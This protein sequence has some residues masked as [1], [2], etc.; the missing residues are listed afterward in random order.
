MNLT[1]RLAVAETRHAQIVSRLEA[2][3]IARDELRATA[4]KERE[5]Y[6]AASA[7]AELDDGARP[8]RARLTELERELPDAEDRVA[9]LERAVAEAAR[10]MRHARADVLTAQAEGVRE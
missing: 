5:A 9:V 2:A 1:E 6:L 8:S 3:R 4:A 7:G 10:Q